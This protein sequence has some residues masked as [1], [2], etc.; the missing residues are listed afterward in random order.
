MSRPHKTIR[1]PDPTSPFGE[2]G[3]WLPVAKCPEAVPVKAKATNP[4][5]EY[6]LPFR[7]V[8]VGTDWLHG[9]TGLVLD[10]IT[11]TKWHR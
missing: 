1:L 5:G 11:I 3:P 9:T 7:V 10:Q 4:T 6:K 8:R 2:S